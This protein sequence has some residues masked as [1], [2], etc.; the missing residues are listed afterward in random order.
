MSNNDTQ[1][2]NINNIQ[3]NQRNIISV[4]PTDTIEIQ[5]RVIDWR[6]LFRKIKSISPD[7]L[8]RDL[9]AGVFWGI[10]GSSLLSLISF[11]QSKDIESWVKPTFW[12]IFVTTGIIGFIIWQCIKGNAKNVLAIREELIIDMKELHLLYFPSEDLDKEDKEANALEE[13]RKKK[14]FYFPNDKPS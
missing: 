7:F 14:E 11:Y 10:S 13:L 1:N 12:G 4:S 5:L 8:G 3:L 2:D 6:R 9:F